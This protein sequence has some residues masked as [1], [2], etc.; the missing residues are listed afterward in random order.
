MRRPVKRGGAVGLRAV[1]IGA[2]LEKRR[3]G[4]GIALLDG[5]GQPLIGAAPR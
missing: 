4:R 2:L 1:D 3:D 5:V